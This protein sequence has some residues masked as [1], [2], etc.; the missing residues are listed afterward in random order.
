VS[1]CLQA[2]IFAVGVRLRWEGTPMEN[3]GVGTENRLPVPLPHTPM[4]PEGLRMG[5]GRDRAAGE[6]GPWSSGGIW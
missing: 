5:E 3:Q 4:I 2:V 1:L 6:G